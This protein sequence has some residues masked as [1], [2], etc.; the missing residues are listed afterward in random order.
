VAGVTNR[1]IR[2]RLKPRVFFTRL[3]TALALTKLAESEDTYRHL[4]DAYDILIGLAGTV[5]LSDRPAR[6][7]CTYPPETTQQALDARFAMVLHGACGARFAA[8]GHGEDTFG[9][10]A[11]V[12]LGAA[13]D[14][15]AS[16]T[17]VLV[18]TRRRPERHG[19]SGVSQRYARAVSAR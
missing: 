17:A 14:Q 3:N 5:A 6:A 18:S 16:S 12:P 1:C 19:Q 8:L 10:N 9:L 11:T 13:L 2:S 4:H 7:G 15:K